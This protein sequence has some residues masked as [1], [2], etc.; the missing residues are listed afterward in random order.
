MDVVGKRKRSE[1]MSGI[2]GKDTKPELLIRSL[3]H[4][5][6][7][8]YHLHRKGLPGK[9]DLVFPKYKAVIEVYGCFWHGHDCHLFKWPATRKEFWQDKINKNRARDR[10]NLDKL[11]NDGWKTLV[12]WECAIRG[13]E[14]LSTLELLKTIEAWLLYDSLDAQIRGRSKA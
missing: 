12:I 2:K 13:K 11:Q 1:M 14:K 8:R 4:R 5:K 7:F 10:S 6:G 9:P 3:L